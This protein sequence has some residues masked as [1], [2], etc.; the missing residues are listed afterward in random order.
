MLKKD[1]Y[2]KKLTFSFTNT[3]SQ[4]AHFKEYTFMAVLFYYIFKIRLKK[5]ENQKSSYAPDNIHFYSLI[6]S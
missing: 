4:K 5:S 3:Y 6:L 1:K 2:D